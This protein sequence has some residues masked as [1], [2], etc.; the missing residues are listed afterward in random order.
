MTCRSIDTPLQPTF[1]GINLSNFLWGA[2]H[3][4]YMLAFLLGPAKNNFSFSYT[5]SHQMSNCATYNHTEANL[6]FSFQFSLIM[7]FAGCDVV[8]ISAH[9]LNSLLFGRLNVD[10]SLVP[11][12]VRL[13]GIR[14]YGKHRFR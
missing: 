8:L 3:L 2:K 13:F 14:Y 12:H 4:I 11:F 6:F 1:S 7:S 5:L 9:S 10:W